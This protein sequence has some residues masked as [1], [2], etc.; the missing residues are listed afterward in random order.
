[1][2][3]K[4]TQ[5]LYTYFER[6]AE[7]KLSRSLTLSLSLSHFLLLSFSLLLTLSLFSLSLLSFFLSLCACFWFTDF[8]H[9]FV[10]HVTYFN[11]P[12]I[13]R[14]TR[15]KNCKKSFGNHLSCAVCRKHRVF[16][17]NVWYMYLCYFI[18]AF[19]KKFLSYWIFKD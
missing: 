7:G 2:E 8:I 17:Q 1:M 19:N 9:S 16:F 4:G 12:F 18:S 3:F 6:S 5:L 15:L 13:Y 10:I 11:F 14:P